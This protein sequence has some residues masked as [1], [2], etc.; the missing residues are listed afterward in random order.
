MTEASDEATVRQL[1]NAV[2]DTVLVNYLRR[3]QVV[4]LA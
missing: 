4:E 3:M 1:T 2:H